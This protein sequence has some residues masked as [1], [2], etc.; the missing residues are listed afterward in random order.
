MAGDSQSVVNQASA[1][2]GCA[3]GSLASGSCANGSIASGYDASEGLAGKASAGECCIKGLLQP[4]Q[5]LPTGLALS[6]SNPST[7]VLCAHQGASGHLPLGTIILPA[8]HRLPPGSFVLPQ[9]TSPGG[10]LRLALPSHLSAQLPTQLP[11]QLP[12]QP[13][14]AAI[15]PAAAAALVKPVPSLSSASAASR[16]RHLVTLRQL[17]RPLGCLLEPQQIAESESAAGNA[18]ATVTD[19]NGDRHASPAV[20]HAA[21]LCSRHA[22]GQQAAT[23]VE[24]A[25]GGCNSGPHGVAA[26]AITGGGSLVASEGTSMQGER[27]AH[28]L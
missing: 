9:G 4:Q 15:P 16:N 23:D 11:T 8:N 5:L 24:G 10:P 7:S 22:P 6:N 28:K 2:R 14:T 18:V 20:Q 25:E 21:E 27:L 13:H 12:S 26:S 3:S 1:N 19:G 17:H